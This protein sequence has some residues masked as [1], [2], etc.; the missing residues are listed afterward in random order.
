MGRF[1][2]FDVLMGFLVGSIMSR[3][4]TGAIRLIDM[5]I[6][7]ASLM[8][9]HWVFS[10]LTYYFTHLSG[11]VKTSSRKLIV[12]G[13]VQEDAMRKSKLGEND[14]LQAVR[15][16]ANLESFDHVETAYL[17]RDGVITVIPKVREPRVLEITVQDGVQ[18]VKISLE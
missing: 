13:E 7:I 9:M 4:I 11:L 15:T 6:I 8:A 18:T 16:K 3:A 12:N 10:T 1:T 17:E 14:L 2:A 5:I